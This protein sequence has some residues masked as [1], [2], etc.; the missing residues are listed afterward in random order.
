[1]YKARHIRMERIV[2]L[3][4][5]NK[6]RLP[7]A[8]AIARF[9]R[10]VRAVARLRHPNIVMGYD[11]SQDR[12]VHYFAMEYVEGQDLAQM[13]KDVGSLPIRS[14]CDY[15]RQAALGLQHAHE[16][17]LVHRDIKPANL[18]IEKSTGAVKVLDFGLA[19]FATETRTA[20]HLTQINRLVGTVD[21]ISPEQ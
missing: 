13:V 10:E 2:A 3:K 17:G 8:S 21:Y 14:A 19:R 20:G 4:V 9:H 11:C 5:I 18:L 16:N 15:M 1:V 6:E 12:E 7:G